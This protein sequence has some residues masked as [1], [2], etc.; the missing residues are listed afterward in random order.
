MHVVVN[1]QPEDVGEVRTVAD[2]LRARSVLP[3][4][5]AVELN[6]E[7]VTR[8][9]YEATKVTEGDLIEIVTFVGGG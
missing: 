2:L 8:D 7:L 1:G 5:V 3:H 9:C 6:R 4:R